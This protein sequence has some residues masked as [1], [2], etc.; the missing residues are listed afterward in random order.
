[1]AKTIPDDYID[2]LLKSEMFM[3]DA[4]A[5]PAFLEGVID[6][7]AEILEGRVGSTAY[8][9][10]TKPQ[11]TYVKQAEK[12]L[13]S[14]ELLIRRKNRILE[15]VTAN[16]QEPPDLSGL[17]SQITLYA[18]KAEGWIGRVASSTSA[19]SGDDAASG[20]VV[21]DHFGGTS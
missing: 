2:L 1:M 16:S 12:C 21:S 18:N 11:S 10:A 5:F 14:A 6:E 8:A 15:T 19:D 4:T 3:K 13:V 7:Q 9:S 17:D 20:V